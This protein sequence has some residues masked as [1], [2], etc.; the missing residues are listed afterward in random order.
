MAAEF[1]RSVI[2][3]HV[4]LA[5]PVLVAADPEARIVD[6]IGDRLLELVPSPC[7]EVHRATGPTEVQDTVESVP[8]VSENPDDALVETALH[9]V[10]KAVGRVLGLIAVGITAERGHAA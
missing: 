6:W 7:E 2:A 1:L 5:I 10:P 8:D 3:E 9:L 4:K